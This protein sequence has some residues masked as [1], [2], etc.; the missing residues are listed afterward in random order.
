MKSKIGN[1]PQSVQL[2]LYGWYKQ[3][4]L[5]NCDDLQQPAPAAYNLVAKA[6]HQAW[7]Q[8]QGMPRTAAMQMYID[9]AVLIEFTNEI[10]SDNLTDDLEGEAVMDIEGFGIRQSTLMGGVV[11]EEEVHS[12]EEY[13]NHYPLHYA[14]RENQLQDLKELLQTTAYDNNP[15]TLD[16]SGQ[17]A[18]HL[19]ADRGH[20]ESIKL[21]L[22]A[23]ANVSAADHDGI[24]VLQAAVI[25]GNVEACQLLC[26]LGANPDQPDSDGDTPLMCA[27]DD[28]TLRELLFRASQGQLVLD[29]DF[30]KELEDLGQMPICEEE[31]REEEEEE[32]FDTE[33]G[34]VSSNTFLELKVFDSPVELDLDDDGDM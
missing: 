9:K 23:G 3:A 32:F 20:V 10:Q 11:F 2:E 25:A 18:L 1:L 16:P 19:A 31:D 4:T 5:G 26:Q 30:R 6:K 29:P 15:D 27:E 12:N 14:A 17:T 8:L 33:E 22:K 7:N 28:P 24:S 34:D 13:G 21:L